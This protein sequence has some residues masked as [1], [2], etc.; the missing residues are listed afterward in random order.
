MEPRKFNFAMQDSNVVMHFLYRY[1]LSAQHTTSFW[2]IITPWTSNDNL[3]EN[4]VSLVFVAKLIKWQK[5]KTALC[6][7]MKNGLPQ[8]LSGLR[9][10]KNLQ[11]NLEGKSIQNCFL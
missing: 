6:D 9:F 11:V 2:N 10:A 7:L 4:F 1:G 3:K 8:I 5:F